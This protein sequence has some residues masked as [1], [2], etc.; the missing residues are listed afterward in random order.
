MPTAL[1]A[2]WSSS[3]KPG[4]MC[5][6]PVPSSVDTKSPARTWNARSVAK[7]SVSVK[8]SNSGRYVAPTSSSPRTVATGSSS[9]S[10]PSASSAA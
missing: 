4:A 5:T 6:M 7:R 3:P 10:T 1:Q 2:I 9:P 8:K